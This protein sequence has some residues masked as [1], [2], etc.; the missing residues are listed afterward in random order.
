M[1]SNVFVITC[2]KFHQ[3]ALIVLSYIFLSILNYVCPIHF[4]CVK[5]FCVLPALSELNASLISFLITYD[6]EWILFDLALPF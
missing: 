3:T 6:N 5:K 1:D 4:I 2:L